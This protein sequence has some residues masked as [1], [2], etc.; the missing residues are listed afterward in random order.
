VRGYWLLAAGLTAGLCLATLGAVVPYPDDADADGPAIPSA[1]LE[2]STPTAPVDTPPAAQAVAPEV[3]R[4]DTAPARL[5]NA[6]PEITATPEWRRWERKKAAALA[7]IGQAWRDVETEDW[8]TAARIAG[9]QSRSG[10]L[11][12]A[13]ERAMESGPDRTHSTPVLDEAIRLDP[14]N[15]VAR[16][17]L[18]MNLVDLAH[19]GEG[20]WNEARIVELV[21]HLDRI[22]RRVQDPNADLT[23]IEA[24]FLGALE[25]LLRDVLEQTQRAD[26]PALQSLHAWWLANNRTLEP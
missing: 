16:C 15:L 26:L 5:Y 7:A 2:V 1:G 21:G 25:D 13:W 18:V 10:R 4:A 20:V 24:R 22:T 3:P 23:R 17:L 11:P 19:E 8:E 14:E 9:A 6:P 12:Q